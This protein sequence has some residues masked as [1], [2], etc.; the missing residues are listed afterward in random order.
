MDSQKQ[1]WMATSG[2]AVTADLHL[3]AVGI[4][5]GKAGLVGVGAEPDLVAVGA[6]RHKPQLRHVWPR[7]PIGAPRHPHLMHTKRR[8]NEWLYDNEDMTDDP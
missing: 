1:M 5:L 2:I 7:A 8:L 3:D 6:V 4:G